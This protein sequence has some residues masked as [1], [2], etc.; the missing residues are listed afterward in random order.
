[1]TPGKEYDV[2]GLE[3]SKGLPF[4]YVNDDVG[5]DYPLGYPAPLFEVVDPAPTPGWVIAVRTD[6]AAEYPELVMAFPPWAED[7]Y[8]HSD[9]ASGDARGG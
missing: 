3:V 2:R 9:L 7:R 5:S 1:L 8:F 4:I 6:P